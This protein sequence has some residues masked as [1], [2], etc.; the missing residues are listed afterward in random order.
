MKANQEIRDM[1]YISRLKNWQVAEKA[2]ITGSTLSVWL[3]TE[4]SDV[5]KQRVLNAID[6]LKKE[7]LS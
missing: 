1:M 2:G 7:M 5:R 3:R 6:E 4:L